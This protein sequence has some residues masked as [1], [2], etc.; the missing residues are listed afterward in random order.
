MKTVNFNKNNSIFSPNLGKSDFG[1][2]HGNGV[3]NQNFYNIFFLVLCGNDPS[4]KVSS[5]SEV[6]S[7]TALWQFFG[8]LRELVVKFRKNISQKMKLRH[9]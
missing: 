1:S 2:C 5:N 6:G 9:V 8:F 7:G 3:S 4:V